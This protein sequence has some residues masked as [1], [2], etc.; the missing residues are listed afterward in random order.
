MPLEDE[1]L[2]QRHER[3]AQIRQ[4]GFEPYGHAFAY[5]HTIPD[6]LS[7]NTARK[8]PKNCA[9]RSRSHSGAHP[10]HSPHGQGRLS[11]PSA[12][13]RETADVHQEGC[14][15][16]I[17]LQALRTARYRRHHRR[18]R[19]SV[20]HQNR[21]AEHSRRRAFL[22]FEDHAGAPGKMARARRCRDT[23]SAALSGSHRQSGSARSLRH[24]FENYPLIPPPAR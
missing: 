24:A 21:R 6:N 12:K 7:P 23:L 5:T 3:L 17:Q 8:P 1:L 11:P 10:D 18:E 9:T 22:S 15:P 13:R 14:G 2:R 4:L 19:V 16:G 20:P